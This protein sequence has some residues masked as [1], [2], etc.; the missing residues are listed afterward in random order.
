MSVIPDV[1]KAN[2]SRAARPSQDPNWTPDRPRARWYRRDFFLFAYVPAVTLIAWCLP[3]RL[4]WPF[5]LA[6]ARLSM[7]VKRNGTVF[8]RRFSELIGERRLEVDMDEVVRAYLANNH[9]LR[10]QGMRLYAPFGW[11]PRLRLVGREHIEHAIAAGKGAILWVAPMA[12]KDLVAKMALHQAGYQV[13][14][15]SRF[16]HG[17]SISLWGARLFNPIWTRIE[18][19]FLAE[20]L[21]ISPREQVNALRVLIKRLRENRLV[22]VAATTEGRKYPHVSPFL[23]ATIKLAEGA[24]SLCVTTGAALV[25]IFNVRQ[26]DGSFV[27]TVEPALLA[28]SN[29]D[30]AQQIDSLIAQFVKLLESYALRYP[31]DYHGWALS[32]V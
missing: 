3:E 28:A 9:L 21:V 11:R 16:D 5:C 1:T 23:N 15:L 7:F 30:A 25:P 10:L 12:C 17:F 2:K 32:G 19:R 26:P 4:W 29:G 27:V 14:H 13:S 31:C 6:L 18:E 20:R 24:A 8:R 22:S